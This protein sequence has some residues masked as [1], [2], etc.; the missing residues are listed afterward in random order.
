[1]A[2]ETGI[3]WTD[4]TQNFW[5]G[6]SKVGP[7]CDHCYA[8]TRNRRF[9]DGANW[10]AGA[11]RRRTSVQAWNQP[12]KWQREADAFEAEHGHP[13]RVFCS[14]L[15][16]VFDNEVDPHWREEAMSIMAQTD[17][18]R[19]Q[20]LTKRVGNVEK[21]VPKTWHP[22]EDRSDGMVR[23]RFHWP[24]H[25]GLMITVVTG[26]EVLRDVPKLLDLKKR[27]GI[28]WVGLSIE[29]LIEDIS[30]ELIAAMSE[31]GEVDWMIVGGESGAGARRYDLAWPRRIIQ[32][33]RIVGIPVFHKQL[34]ENAWRS[35]SRFYT[36]HKKGE[37][38]SEWPDDLVCREFPPALLS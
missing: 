9:A 24:K 20:L 38:P 1:M 36:A 32:L 10:G 7:G 28:P 19:W 5:E 34:G 18:L 26:V 11:P 14:S 37:D 17:R 22:A 2:G 27:F 25:I 23:D 13:R 35:D 21:M 15:A 3:A 8:E 16:D 33:G 31:H 29:P 6:C 12:A 4:S 30:Q